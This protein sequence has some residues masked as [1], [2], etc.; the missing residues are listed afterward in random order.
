MGSSLLTLQ[1]TAAA[2]EVLTQAVQEGHASPRRRSSRDAAGARADDARPSLSRQNERDA[3]RARSAAAGAARERGGA[4]AEDLVIALKNQAHL[5]IDEGRYDAGGARRAGGGRRRRC[6]RWASEHPETVAALLMRALRVSIQPQPGRGL[7][8]GRARVSHWRS[9]CIATRPSTR[10]PSRAACSTV[11]RSR[12]AGE[13]AR[14]VEQLA[15]AGQRCGRG[16][17][18]VE[19]HGRV[20]S[21]CRSPNFSWRPGRSREA[22]ENSRKAVD[23]IAQHTQA[24]VLQIR[25]RHPSARRRAPRGATGRRGAAR[26]DARRRDAAPPLPAA[27][28]TDAGIQADQALA[29]ARAGAID[30]AQQ[31]IEGILPPGRRPD[32]RSAQ[33]ALRPGRRQA[34]RRRSS[35]GA[36]PAAAVAP[37]DARRPEW[38]PGSH[39][40]LTEM[41]LNLHELAKSEQAPG[42][43]NR[44]L[45]SSSRRWRSPGA[46]SRG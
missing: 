44:R 33:A 34:A 41:G 38:R 17:R 28:R 5:E 19:P 9:R 14:G 3:R 15:Q 42:S 1:D 11:A 7:A 43:P 24:R 4:R 12:E 2:D 27:A 37:V 29:L 39:A 36:P 32:D 45:R 10:A 46:R 8:G 16:L 21:R 25:G 18:A 35:R 6:T 22:L 20:L 13:L 26:P 23:I 31:M 30:E 40:V